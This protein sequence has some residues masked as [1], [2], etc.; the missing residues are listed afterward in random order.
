MTP[1]PGLRYHF[2][3]NPASELTTYGWQMRFLEGAQRVLDVGCGSGTLGRHLAARGCAVTGIEQDPAAAVYCRP[4]Y[5]RVVV[6]D[7]ECAGVRAQVA[8]CYDAVVLGDV[9]EHLKAPADML[10]HV[11]VAWLRPDG[12]VVVSLPNAGHWIFRRE[13][14]AGRF[15]YRAY[16]LFDRDHLRFFTLATA[17]QLVAECE[18]A[19]E[20]L[21]YAVNWNDR[22][23][24]TFA[25]LAFAYRRPTLAPQLIRLER[26][27]AWRWPALFA[28]QI[29]FRLRPAAGAA[30]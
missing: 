15:P 6:G 24:L 4:A 27:L 1:P 7:V 28:Y 5:V 22:D 3:V 17:R 30:A 16:G 19:V 14:L 11:R 10:R 26:W 21:A 29:I 12:R 20:R 23:D 9:L 8:E 2:D 18:Y 13:V 25:S